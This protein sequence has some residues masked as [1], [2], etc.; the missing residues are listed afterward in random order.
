MPATVEQS[1]TV[2]IAIFDSNQR[3]IEQKRITLTYQMFSIKDEADVLKQSRAQNAAYIKIGTFLRGNVDGS[4]A[5][6]MDD[7][8]MASKFLSEFDNSF[9]VLPDLDDVTL[10]EALHRKLS[11]LAGE[12]SCVTKLQLYDHD[13]N[14]K[15][16]FYYE[17][18]DTQYNLPTIDEWL[19]ELSFWEKPWWDRYDVLTFDNVADDIA[20]RDA[21]REDAENRA[22]TYRP[23]DEIDEE[24]NQMMDNMQKAYDEQNGIERPGGEL[25]SLEAVRKKK[26]KW[27][28]TIV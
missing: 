18:E 27:K 23:L 20:E 4:V 5:F 24:I 26:G 9:M 2:R 22:H 1:N 21:H 7:M 15:Y 28:P 13:L 8:P 14:I 3:Y 12:L 16:N 6:T 10:L 17:D 25:V 19:G 11:V